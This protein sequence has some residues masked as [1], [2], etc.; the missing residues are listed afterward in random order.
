MECEHDNVTVFQSARE[1]YAVTNTDGRY[2]LG[3]KMEVTDIYDVNVEC[4]D[5]GEGNL[6]IDV[7]GTG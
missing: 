3:E 4:G 7:E 6:D 1:W 5:C 2:V